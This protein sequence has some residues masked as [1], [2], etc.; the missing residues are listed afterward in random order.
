MNSANHFCIQPEKRREFSGAFSWQSALGESL[1][2]LRQAICLASTA[3]CLTVFPAAAQFVAKSVVFDGATPY[4]QSD[5]RAA[6]NLKPGTSFTQDSLQK[7][8]Q[9]L[10]DTGAFSSVQASVDGPPQAMTVTVKVQAR[11]PSQML[12]VTF[13][14]F[15]WPQADLAAELHKRV[16]LFNG[17][18][19]EAGNLQTATT[20]ALQKM[21]A[22][23]KINTSIAT[24]VL[25][26]IPGHAG[27]ILE[28]RIDAPSAPSQ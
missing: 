1:M 28:F 21:L 18:L 5:L 6:A 12:E 25:D 22:E 20:D 15:P 4:S 24:H 16:P 19:P 26:A 3:L 7:I 9:G 10:Q 23:K 8:T 14:N 17:T 27:R 13:V 2:H 11:S